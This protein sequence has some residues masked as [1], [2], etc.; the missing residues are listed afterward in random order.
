MGNII[1]LTPFA[2]KPQTETEV[3]PITFG[4]TMRITRPK[5]KSTTV[6]PLGNRAVVIPFSDETGAPKT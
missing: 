4:I 6:Q 3:R 1:K 2:R 5:A